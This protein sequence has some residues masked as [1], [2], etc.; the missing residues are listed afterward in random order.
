MALSL[1][2]W[3]KHVAP[4]DERTRIQQ[5]IQFSLV[6]FWFIEHPVVEHIFRDVPQG[7]F[8]TLVGSSNERI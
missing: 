5:R 6:F 1:F 2:L 3:A 7:F 4:H 8:K